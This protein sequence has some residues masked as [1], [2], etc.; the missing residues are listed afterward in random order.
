MHLSA[1][2]FLLPAG[3]DIVALV[4]LPEPALGHGRVVA[5]VDARDVVSLDVVDGVRGEVARER[6][7]QVVAQRAKLA[8]LVG[9]VV[10]ELGIL[11]VLQSMHVT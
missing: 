9:E 5:S 6:H 11:A 8:A 2:L 1:L 3:S 10:D 4:E 7:G